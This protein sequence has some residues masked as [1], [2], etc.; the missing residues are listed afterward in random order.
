MLLKRSGTAPCSRPPRGNP[1]QCN[2]VAREAHAA[3][4]GLDICA[5]CAVLR[6]D[7]HPLKPAGYVPLDTF[8]PA[9]DYHQRYFERNPW[10]GYC[11]AVIAP[12]VA[13]FRKAYAARLK[14]A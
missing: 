6:P 9:E 8:W 12:K 14:V 4:L 11:R 5:F 7:R 1:L 10:A 3:S 13:K 2:T